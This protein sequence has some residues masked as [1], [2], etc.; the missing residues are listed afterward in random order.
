MKKYLIYN[1]ILKSS[2]RALKKKMGNFYGTGEFL[3][4]NL[5]EKGGYFA[6]GNSLY[7]ASAK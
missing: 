3:G 7:L 6:W 5:E 4:P 2:S 1:S